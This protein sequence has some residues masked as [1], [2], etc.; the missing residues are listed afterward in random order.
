M[1]AILDAA[2]RMGEGKKAKG[3]IGEWV[4]YL[5][6]WGMLTFFPNVLNRQIMGYSVEREVDLVVKK[7]PR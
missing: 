5:F 7:R 1:E 2:N 3:F 6:T 4:T